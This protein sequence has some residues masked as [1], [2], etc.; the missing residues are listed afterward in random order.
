MLGIAIRFVIAIGAVAGL[1]YWARRRI[2]G[3]RGLARASGLRVISRV[4]VAK[5]ATVVRIATGEK[6]IL[7]GC[8]AERVTNLA[9][10]A[11][12][13]EPVPVL[14]D[15]G[16]DASLPSRLAR[17]GASGRNESFSAVLRAAVK[18]RSQ[19]P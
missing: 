18:G 11:P 17:F 3:P 19:A 4:S 13:K 15:T 2:G 7:L 1:L 6:D 9:E 10:L 14:E 5:G 12:S 8:T 16:V